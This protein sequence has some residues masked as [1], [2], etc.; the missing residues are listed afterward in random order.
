MPSQAPSRLESVDLLRGLVMILMALDHTRDFLGNT[1]IS[2]TNLAQAS[3]A[4]FLTRWITHFCAPVFFLLTGAGARLSLARKSR[5]SLS[6]FLLTRGLWLILLELTLFRCLG[7]QWNFD[8]RLT[9]LN[10]LWALGWAMIALSA[11]IHLPTWSIAALSLALI[12]AHNAFDSLRP[13]SALAVILH[14]P[15]FVLNTPS[16]AVFAAYPL[17]PWIGVTSLGYVLAGVFSWPAP[18]RRAFL[19]RAGAASC[20]AFV[21]LRFSNLYGDPSPWT[22]QRSLLFTALSFLNTTK[23]PPSLL[24]LLMTLGPALLLLAAADART[25]APLRPA[26][27]YGRVPLFY[28]LLHIPLIHAIA[29]AVC[30]VRYHSA[31]WMFSSPSV[32][33]FPI[34]APPAWGLPLPALYA[35]W[36]AVAAALYLPCLRFGALKRRATHAWLSYL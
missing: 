19:F 25:P 20:A 24:F 2:P 10:V 31:G 14:S 30:L 13:A 3:A 32:D 5:R 21:L 18:R 35:V 7:F 4:L 29:L 23:Y 26:L 15:G 8:Y 6:L 34:T 27:V 1:S 33:R 12:A 16:H 28:F 17:I 22:P 36:L 9:L 11:L